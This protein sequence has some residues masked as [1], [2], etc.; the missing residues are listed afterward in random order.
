MVLP[1][2]FSALAP[3][4]LAG[5]G[6]SALTAS[7][8]GAGL[9]GLVET[10]DLEKGIMAGL[11][12]F[13][14]GSIA[15]MLGGAAG[16]TPEALAAQVPAGQTAIPASGGTG[17]TALAPGNAGIAGL[18][19][20]QL[21][22][23][24]AALASSTAAPMGIGSLKDMAGKAFEFAKS[25]VGKGAGIGATIGSSIAPMLGGGDKEKPSAS[26]RPPGGTQPIPR[27]VQ[28]P[29]ADYQPGISPEFDYGIA[30]IQTPQQLRDYAKVGAIP[31]S[32][33]GLLR[34]YQAMMGPVKLAEGGIATLAETDAPPMPDVARS[35]GN[36]KTIISDAVAAIKGQSGNP[37]VALAVFLQKYG[38]EALR[39]LVDRVTSG[40]FDGNVASSTGK[41]A[42]PGDGMED[43]IP[44]TIEGEQDVLLSDGEYV[45][46]ADVV[47]GLGNGSS[48]AGARTLDKMSERVRVARTGDGKQPSR[49]PQEEVLPA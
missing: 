35:G 45:V 11:G 17:M 34:R 36:D 1:L 19:P 13:A 26:N 29:G 10:G 37:E 31:Y 44:A 8:L 7:A 4:L 22:P 18:T 43:L 39:D 48:D 49:V 33:G 47:S 27:D 9:G 21:L 16:A 23:P 15:P 42:G 14:G 3:Q 24:Q 28:M 46:P 32:D 30:G 2:I 12:A 41:M 40:E 5:T 20:D 38:E 6:M 25:P